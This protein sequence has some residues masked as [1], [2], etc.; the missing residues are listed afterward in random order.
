MTMNINPSDLPLVERKAN[1]PGSSAVAASVQG[2]RIPRRLTRTDPPLLTHTEQ[3]KL[4]QA[5]SVV[6]SC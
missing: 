2:A 6:G 3:L 1:G 5:I 4:T